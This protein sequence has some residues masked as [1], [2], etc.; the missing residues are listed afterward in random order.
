MKRCI[1]VIALV[2]VGW[3]AKKIV[4]NGKEFNCFESVAGDTI[5]CVSADQDACYDPVT[6][7]WE[8]CY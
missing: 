3:V 8:P 5:V 1:A 4:L 7:R 6:K 2:V